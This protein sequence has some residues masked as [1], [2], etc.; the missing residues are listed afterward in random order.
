MNVRQAGTF[1]AAQHGRISVGRTLAAG[2]IQRRVAMHVKGTGSTEDRVA[3][4]LAV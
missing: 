4:E 2:G 3:L 1:D